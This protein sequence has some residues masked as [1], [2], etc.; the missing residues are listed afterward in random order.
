MKTY[1]KLKDLPFSK[2]YFW[3]YDF[4][5]AELPIGVIIEQIIIYGDLGDHLN[6]FNVFPKEDVFSSYYNEI[7]PRLLGN[8]K[9]FLQ[10]RPGAT[11]KIEGIRRIKYMDLIFEVANV[12]A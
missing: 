11:P 5:K 3:S 10:E 9:K 7:R 2:R 6:L 1:Y 12:A 8:D 4:N